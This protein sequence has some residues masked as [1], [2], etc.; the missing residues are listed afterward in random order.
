M[1]NKYFK[2]QAPL[3]LCRTTLLLRAVLYWAIPLGKATGLAEMG[4][5]PGWW[6]S[7]QRW[8]KI[9][10]PTL[11]KFKCL[12]LVLV[13]LIYTPDYRGFARLPSPLCDRRIQLDCIIATCSYESSD[14]GPC[15]TFCRQSLHS[16]TESQTVF[17]D[18]NTSKS[19]AKSIPGTTNN[20]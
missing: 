5:N 7:Q 9:E 4:T 11:T 6:G 16:P 17:P 2:R 15:W 18:S 20:R 14:E 8:H 12:K 1:V 3:S 13:A 10:R 19:S